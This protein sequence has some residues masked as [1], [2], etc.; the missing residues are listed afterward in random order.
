MH[1][2]VNTHTYIC[3]PCGETTSSTSSAKTTTK[4]TGW[5]NASICWDSACRATR[6]NPH[7]GAGS[8]VETPHNK[9]PTIPPANRATCARPPNHGGV[10]SRLNVRDWF[11]FFVSVVC[12]CATVAAPSLSSSVLAGGLVHNVNERKLRTIGAIECKHRGRSCRHNRYGIGCSDAEMIT[13]AFV[14]SS[15]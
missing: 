10:R 3:P 2:R 14:S 8:L 5:L 1:A 6:F 13:L 15:I 12:L 9:P 7:S 11:G 4:K